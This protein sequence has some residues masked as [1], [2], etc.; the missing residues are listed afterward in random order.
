LTF[1][2][3][4]PPA[5]RIP[6][7]DGIASLVAFGSLVGVPLLAA[8]FPR[9]AARMALP[10][11]AVTSVGV[12]LTVPDTERVRVVMALMLIVAVV[13][14][15]ANIEPN[16]FVVAAIAFVIIAVAILDS[17]GRGA[18]IARAAGC[19]G[20]LLAAPIAHW[21]PRLQPTND[22]RD[23]HDERR[24]AV[25]TLVIVHCLVVGWASR[26]LIRQTSVGLVVLACGAALVLAT[27]ILFATGRP[28]AADP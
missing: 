6:S 22:A 3:R 8:C 28:V 17:G 24:P 4:K 13:G 2:R 1:A 11:L 19:F 9:W 14:F 25:V 20:V 21:L 10:L 5:G 12:Y 18:A 27:G 16:R 23:A 7:L 26:A 15:A